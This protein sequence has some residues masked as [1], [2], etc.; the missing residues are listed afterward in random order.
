MPRLFIAIDLPDALKDELGALTTDIAGAV[1]AKRASYHLTL[2]FLGNDIDA[3]RIPPI[4]RAL[5]QI[6]A[7][8]FPLMLRSVGRFP[9]QPKQPARV[10]W[11][12]VE[13]SPA[14]LDLHQAVA[15]AVSAVDF[16]PE[17]RAFNPHITLARLKNLKRDPAVTEFLTAHEAF[18]PASFQAQAFHL[19]ESR[20]TP[21][22]AQYTTRASFTLSDPS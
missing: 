14:L 12:G 21:Q 7:A 17:D 16:P 13:A 10:L 15:H 18:A 6:R 20:L 11:V 2:R 9:K 3:I 22:G 4:T 1:W 8:S 5:G 19:I